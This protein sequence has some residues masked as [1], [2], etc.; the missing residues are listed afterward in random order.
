MVTSYHEWNGL[1]A[2]YIL[3]FRF[4]YLSLNYVSSIS[5]SQVT[6]LLIK[7]H[8]FDKMS[9]SPHRP[10]VTKY[11]ASWKDARIFR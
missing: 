10:S 3:I 1:A 8:S 2:T 9:T 11:S 4:N 6:F 5:T 7:K